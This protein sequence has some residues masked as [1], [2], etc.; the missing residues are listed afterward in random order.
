MSSISKHRDS[1][2]PQFPTENL[3]PK[4]NRAPRVKPLKT[5]EKQENEVAPTLCVGHHFWFFVV[6]ILVRIYPSKPAS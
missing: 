6:P 3:N 4:A 1:R 5:A 2:P